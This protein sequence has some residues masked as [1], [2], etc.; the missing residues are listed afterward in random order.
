MGT[1]ILFL[2]ICTA[3]GAY[4]GLR[5]IKGSASKAQASG[6]TRDQ[7]ETAD[8]PETRQAVERWAQAHGYE[9][10]GD[11]TTLLRY[12]KHVAAKKGQPTFLDVR[13]GDGTLA[14][15]SY[16]GLVHPLTRKPQPGE[17]PLGAPGMILAIPRK[18]AK[19]EHNVLRA[20]LGLPEIA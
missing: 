15:E 10:A 2:L 9:R 13:P 17:V 16:V 12:Q 18:A 1:F 3:I 7:V 20:E 14:L 5:L 11:G 4:F 6:Y 8:T 19:R